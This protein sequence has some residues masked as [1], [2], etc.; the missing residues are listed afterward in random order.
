IEVNPLM[1]LFLKTRRRFLF[2]FKAVELIAFLALIYFFSFMS[3]ERAFYALLIVLL[4]YS[5]VVVQGLVV[6]LR[7]VGN[8]T[9]VA[10]LFLALCVIGL[11][12]IYLNYLTFNNSIA[13]SNALN[14][15]GA[16][17]AGLY[18]NC[19]GQQASSTLP[20]AVNDFGLNLT[21]PR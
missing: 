19:T 3:A 4:V 12:F 21:I 2:V 8:A 10:L 20:S 14:A 16:K 7:A 9:P 11:V 17:Y 1:K 5:F 18:W 13:I 6:Y 15:C